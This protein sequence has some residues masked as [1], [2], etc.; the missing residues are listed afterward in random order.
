M[1]KTKVKVRIEIEGLDPSE[2]IQ[3]FVK[4]LAESVADQVTARLSA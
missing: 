4:D 2:E 1:E 3:G